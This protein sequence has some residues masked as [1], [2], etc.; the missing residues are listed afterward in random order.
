MA[1][2]RLRLLRAAELFSKLNKAT[3]DR[4]IVYQALGTMD[5][6]E[7]R[8]EAAEDELLMAVG[9]AKEL[10]RG[11]VVG[12]RSE[13]ARDADQLFTSYLNSGKTQMAQMVAEELAETALL[14]PKSDSVSP[15]L[16]R[17]VSSDMRSRLFLRSG[18]LQNARIESGNAIDGFVTIEGQLRY[19]ET[20][21]RA[22]AMDT[23]GWINM[24]GGEYSSA[25]SQFDSAV[26]INRYPGGVK[27]TVINAD[28]ALAKFF[29]D[30]IEVSIP[31]YLGTHSNLTPD[32]TLEWT[33]LINLL[34]D[35][36]YTNFEPLR[37]TLDGDLLIE[38]YEG[39]SPP[40]PGRF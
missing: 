9:N 18:D 25:N 4:A 34:K 12:A 26:K 24:V 2:A 29:V 22:I 32:E 40:P 38:A 19:K 5:E 33:V 39:N 20:Q 27:T 15:I 1:S 37:K 11:G 31:A 30:S 36:N 13:L 8:L 16:I 3:F 17:S 6:K 28:A 21:L 10:T 7:G 23:L 35:S 14:L